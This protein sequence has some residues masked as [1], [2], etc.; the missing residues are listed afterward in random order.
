LRPLQARLRLPVD[1]DSS[2]VSFLLRQKTSWTISETFTHE[3]TIYQSDIDWWNHT[4]H[5]IIIQ[6]YED[7]LFMAS[8]KENGFSHE[9]NQTMASEPIKSIKVD[10]VNQSYAGQKIMVKI[11]PLFNKDISNKNFEEYHNETQ[12]E[13]DWIGFGGEIR[14]STQPNT[15]I[16]RA[17]FIFKNEY[18]TNSKL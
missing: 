5:A 7:T 16:S 8:N 14:A 17:I 2:C 9:K 12:L 15:L 11:W 18:P 10:Y 13:M 3:F 6:F 4:N 1:F